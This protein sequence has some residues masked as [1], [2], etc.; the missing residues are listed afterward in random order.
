MD[1]FFG[2]RR[3]FMGKEDG[4]SGCPGYPGNA[5]KAGKAGYT[6]KD[7]EDGGVDRSDVPERGK[8]VKDGGSVCYGGGEFG[9][10]LGFFRL[11][12]RMREAQR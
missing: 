8:E 7:V 12:M 5:G 3:F 1:F 9:G 2:V 6:G 4:E 10:D 11:V